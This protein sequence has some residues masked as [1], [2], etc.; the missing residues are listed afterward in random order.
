MQ[1]D[2]QR[3]TCHCGATQYRVSGEITAFFCHCN[4]CRQNSA[5]PVS[6]WGRVKQEDFEV[7]TG[8]LTRFNSSPGVTWLFCKTCGTCIY[9]LNEKMAGDVDFLI[10]TLSEPGAVAPSYH[11]QTAEKLP[12]VTIGDE[13]PQYPRWRNS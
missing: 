4:S 9:Y 13:L 10:S 7:V 12:W 2:T 6:A 5:A 11:V 1:Q 8:E 3:G